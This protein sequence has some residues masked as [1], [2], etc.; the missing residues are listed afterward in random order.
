MC[1]EASWLPC[2]HQGALEGVGGARR[3]RSPCAECSFPALG[4]GAEGG[5]GTIPE[6]S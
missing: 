3:M 5:L 1:E 6:D 4:E 2:P